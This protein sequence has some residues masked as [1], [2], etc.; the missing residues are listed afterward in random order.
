FAELPRFAV[1]LG[2]VPALRRLEVGKL[3]D[4]D[5]RRIPVSLEDRELAAADEV[6][7]AVRR[8]R[9]R[10]GLPVALVLLGV[11]DVGLDDDVCRHGSIVRVETPTH[12]PEETEALAAE[13]AAR[14]AVGDVVTVSGELGSGK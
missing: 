10:R 14:L 8:D 2:V 5:A 11:R 1:L 6:A 3:E 9:G 12:T 13:L 4:D 7:A